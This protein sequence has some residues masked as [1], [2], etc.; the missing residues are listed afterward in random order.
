M[1]AKVELH[2]RMANAGEGGRTS[3]V[4]DNEQ[5]SPAG[6]ENVSDTV[7]ERPLMPVTVMVELPCDP[8]FIEPGVTDPAET[9]KSTML[10][11]M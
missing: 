4:A 9:V 2:E 11:T 7:L 1:L 8:A 6:A 5:V 3:V 10:K